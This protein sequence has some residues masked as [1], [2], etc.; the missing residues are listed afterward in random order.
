MVLPIA[1]T[2]QHLNTNQ[3]QK[4]PLSYS[5]KNNLPYVF[6]LNANVSFITKQAIQHL[7]LEIASSSITN[8]DQSS[9]CQEVEVNMRTRACQRT[10]T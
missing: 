5:H 7:G 10:L 4:P 1:S 8:Q 3:L 9:K 6:P 2:C